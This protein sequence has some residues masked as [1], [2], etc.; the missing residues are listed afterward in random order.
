MVELADLLRI[1]GIDCNLDQY[2]VSP[3][4]GWQNW[5]RNQVEQADFVLLVCTEQY[6]RRF[7]GKEQP[8]KG[9]GVTWEGAIISQLIYD[10]Q[11]NSKFIPIIFESRAND[12]I[13][14][15][16]KSHTYYLLN[17]ANLKLNEPGYEAL[18]R[19]LTNNMLG[20]LIGGWVSGILIWWIS[21]SRG[22][23][24]P[25]KRAQIFFIF[26]LTGC[27]A[28]FFIRSTLGI[29]LTDQY[30]SNI[31]HFVA[32]IAGIIVSLKVMSWLINRRLIGSKSI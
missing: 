32:G 11:S 18:Y 14:L 20:Y 19:H 27:V 25:S 16:I 6:Q 21:Q 13:P 29:I 2:E 26:F 3:P 23:L 28:E 4:E 12:Y 7:Q 31:Q 10:Q 5:M 15:E 9:K 17:P 1:H 24:N 22:N 30:L 8:G